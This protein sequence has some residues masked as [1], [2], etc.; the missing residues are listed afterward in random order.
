MGFQSSA[1]LISAGGGLNKS[2]I[3][4]PLC[5]AFKKAVTEYCSKPKGKRGKFNDTYFK[6]LKDVDRQL[7]GQ[8]R[9]EVPCLMGQGALPGV[10]CLWTATSGLTAA[11]SATA[12]V[13]GCAGALATGAA[14]AAKAAVGVGAP[15][16]LTRAAAGAMDAIRGRSFSLYNILRTNGAAIPGGKLRFPDGMIGQQVIEVKGPGDGFKDKGQAKDYQKISRPKPPI[17]PSCESCKANCTSDGS[18]GGC[19]GD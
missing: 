17:V 18:G 6:K 2:G 10:R 14:A 3:K 5:K 8:I 1:K 19:P 7:A 13:A 9:R 12:A 4:T 16:G 11:G 15:T